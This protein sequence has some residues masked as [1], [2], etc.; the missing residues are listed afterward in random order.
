[1]TNP[2]TERYRIGQWALFAYQ[3]QDYDQ[4]NRKWVHVAVDTMTKVTH[5]VDWSSYDEMT[6]TD[7]ARFL[8]LERPAR[9]NHLPLDSD[10]L[11]LLW[12]RTYG[13]LFTRKNPDGFAQ[14]GLRDKSSLSGAH[15]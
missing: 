7:F 12:W 3:E 4:A 2:Q 14:W 11:E 13:A 10:Q 6:S 1:M 8:D 5:T 9:L 15:S